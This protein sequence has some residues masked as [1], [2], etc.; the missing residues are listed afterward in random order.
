MILTIREVFTECQKNIQSH[1]K[2]LQHLSKIYEKTP[3]NEFWDGFFHHMK[4]SL[5]VLTR[6]P[7]VERMINFI[8]QFATSLS[9]ASREKKKLED[10]ANDEQHEDEMDPFLLKLFNF[11]LEHHAANDKA[12]RFRCCQ[13]IS[14]LLSSLGDDYELEEDL[15]DKVFEVMLKRVKDKCPSVRT[16][17]VLALTR[18]QDP[19]NKEC[20]VISVYLFLL[21]CDP[22]PEVR[23]AVLSAIAATKKT[24]PSILERTKDVKSVVRKFAYNVIAEKIDIRALTIAQRVSL[25]KNGLNDRSIVVRDACI[26]HLMQRWLSRYQGNIL[27][28]LKHLDV[29]NT[30]DTSNQM[31]KAFF[32]KSAVTELV[33]NFDILNQELTIPLEELTS[34]SAL[35]WRSLCSFIK[36]AGMQ[37]EEHLDKILPMG[38]VLASYIEMI[39]EHMKAETNIEAKLQNDFIMEQILEVAALL[40]FS[41]EVG[42]KEIGHI[43]KSLL[44]S[45]FTSCMLVKPIIFVFTFIY[46]DPEQR[47]A[48]LAEI[49]SDIREPI[50]T[51]QDTQHLQFLRQTE[52]KI[53]AIRVELNQMREALDTCIE[54]QNFV[55]AA[56]I[57]EK[58]LE[59]EKQKEMLIEQSE[60][61]SHFEVRVEKNDPA[62]VLKCLTIVS[63]TLEVT[64]LAKLTPVLQTL[65][66]VLILPGVT[67]LEPAVRNA[68][69]RA[70]GLCCLLSEDA[71]KANLLLFM[72]VVQI[73]QEA[74]KVTALKV[75]FDFLHLFGLETFEVNAINDDETMA[76][77]DKSPEFDEDDGVNTSPNHQSSERDGSDKTKTAS[78]ILHILVTLLDSESSDIRTMCAEGLA[79]LM[80][81]GRFIS[82][83]VISRLILLWYNPVTEDDAR[84]RHCLGAFFPIY[85]F[86][87]RANMDVMEEA[88]MPTLNTLFN[89]PLTSPL[90]KVDVRNTAE[91]LTELTSVRHL[92]N[93]QT[94]GDLQ[95]NTPHDNLAVRLCN[96]ILSE[97]ESFG[98]PIFC[99]VLGL[100]ELTEGNVSLLK[101]V[102]VLAG[103]TLKEVADW[104]CKKMLMKFCKT[105]DDMLAD[106]CASLQKTNVSQI[107]DIAEKAEEDPSNMAIDDSDENDKTKSGSEQDETNGECLDTSHANSEQVT[108][109]R[110]AQLNGTA[111]KFSQLSV[112]S[113]GGEE[114]DE[115]SIT[116]T[117]NH[118]RLT[119]RS[120]KRVV[121]TEAKQKQATKLA[122]VGAKSGTARSTRST[123]NTRHLSDDIVAESVRRKL[124]S[125]LSD[126]DSEPN[127]EESPSQPRA[128]RSTRSSTRREPLCD[129]VNG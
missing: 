79:K 116:D 57:K 47:I 6:E 69:L 23:R 76:D 85:A 92:I 80:L 84:L 73:D 119:T 117:V 5:V 101:D 48:V 31:L 83:K 41:D 111:Q 98:L 53:A 121:T 86:S 50:S 29:E 55:E 74:V 38:T 8:V 113:K 82:S 10:E 34:E 12:V 19:Q 124:D 22:S 122:S 39:Y 15:Y 107:E 106:N 103:R 30:L 27:E 88:F 24:L 40:D 125:C 94:A 65:M 32:D 100:L 56:E 64:E 93:R 16:Q 44:L 46:T 35:Y 118:S 13:I 17:A 1:R 128:K 71:A 43:M 120:H 89:A 52:L 108:N 2:L 127:T 104:R 110:A 114:T 51:E 3:F 96:E 62:T 129:I 67:S 20:P 45:E 54:M 112:N 33:N 61:M 115:T 81:A 105:V 77:A 123:R 49:I 36:A 58:V 91:L 28:L 66:E 87:S 26:S 18:L 97:P 75:I 14:K 78:S 11:L 102:K 37:A 70:L 4:Y 9:L 60:S 126:S 72:Q 42:R 68:A 109:K 21:G 25:L 90:S 7:T 95:E 63:E 59:L 99:R